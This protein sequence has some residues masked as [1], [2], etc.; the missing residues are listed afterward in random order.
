MYGA[1][2][3]LCG[4]LRHDYATHFLSRSNTCSRMSGPV[5]LRYFAPIMNIAKLI[6]RCVPGS[7]IPGAF[8]HL[9]R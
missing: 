7:E 8:A 4:T 3:S 9:H 5:H 1:F 6:L 2:S